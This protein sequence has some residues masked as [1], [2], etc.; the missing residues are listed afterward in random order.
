MRLNLHSLQLFVA[1]VEA[2]SIAAAAEREFIAASA[3][4]K[5]IAE[6]ERLL[7][8]P[9][10]LRQARGVEPTAAG[11]V[12]VRG[13]RT[14]LHQAVDLE[15]QVRD[16]ATGESGHVRVAANLSS[17]TQFLPTDL[18]AF[19][20]AHP[21]IQ[22]DLE[23]RI[24]SIVTRMVLDNAADIGVFTFSADEPELDV[25][26][27]REDEVVMVMHK[28]HP[29]APRGRVSFLDT[30]E[31]EHIG[32]QRDSAMGTVMQRV[33]VAAGRELRMRFFVHS[34]DALI[35]M[36]R[37]RLGMGMIPWGAVPLYEQTELA[38]LHLSD[39][40]ARRRIKIGVRRGE[41]L[42]TA[43]R[44]LMDHLLASGRVR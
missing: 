9:L 28:S 16:F 15:V 24:S 4:S 2:G 40:W 21:R 19:T 32:M 30:L 23:E 13:A 44:M 25:H 34:Y 38:T 43:G 7:D 26:P 42:S 36:V 11:R 3:L 10:L 12:L 5:R 33:A 22:I 31:Y 29:L 8:T 37:Q 6:L 41:P 14:L 17:I 35:S 27:Y 20:Q 1:V 39:T 18:R